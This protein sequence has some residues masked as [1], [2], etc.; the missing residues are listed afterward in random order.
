MVSMVLCSFEFESDTL[1]RLAH[2]VSGL[3]CGP[4]GRVPIETAVVVPVEAPVLVVG[5]PGSFVGRCGCGFFQA[6]ILSTMRRLLQG[7]GRLGQ[8]ASVTC[9]CV[10]WACC[11]RRGCRATRVRVRESHLAGGPR[12]NPDRGIMPKPLENPG[13]T[14]SAEEYQFL[15]CRQPGRVGGI[16][17]FRRPDS[18]IRCGKALAWVPPLESYDVTLR[19][20]S[21]WQ[22]LCSC[23]P[24]TLPHE[25]A[26][27][28]DVQS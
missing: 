24:Y 28:D 18:S 27:C 2:S 8:S 15:T 11:C 20:R 26:C 10:Q 7:L 9:R 21:T 17:S 13:K 5:R 25:G 4:E 22:W 6:A 14:A 1:H 3:T 12:K 16:V 23:E 19:E